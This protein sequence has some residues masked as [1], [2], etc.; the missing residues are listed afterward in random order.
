MDLLTVFAVGST[1]WTAAQVFPFT[2]TPDPDEIM[3]E[4]WKQLGISNKDGLLPEKKNGAWFL[5]AG[6]CPKDIQKSISALSYQLNADI[7]MEVRGKGVY[8]RVYPGSLPSILPYEPQDLSDYKLGLTIGKTRKQDCYIFDMND[9]HPYLIVAGAP[10]QGKS[11]FLAQALRQ[12]EDN[13]TPTRIMWH[14]IDL[15]LGVELSPFEGSPFTAGTCWQGSKLPK[16]LS[17]IQKE[18]KARMTL[19]KAAGV[20]K[21]DEYNALDTEPLPYLLIVIDEYAELRREKTAEE[22]M[23]SILQIGRAAGIRCLL[24]TQR[25]SSTNLSTDIRG[26]IAD[27]LSFRLPDRVNS[28]IVLDIPGAEELPCRGRC[29]LLHG[30]ELI[31]AQTM[32]AK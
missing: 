30:A 13:Y 20:L 8:L 22:K 7:E 14:L 28:E 11:N 9:T 24:S 26:L 16:L 2:H 12:I 6:L 17:G 1:L 32:L 19:F 18:I 31:T 4:T 10:G 25:P 21:I 29:L 23:Q 3:L 27:R 5:P 15:K